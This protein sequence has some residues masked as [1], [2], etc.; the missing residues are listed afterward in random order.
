MNGGLPP[1]SYLWSNG[2]TNSSISNVCA[3]NYSCTVTDLVGCTIS[4]NFIITEPPVLAIQTTSVNSNCGLPDGTASVTNIT[5][6]TPGYTY[7]WSNGQT[8]Q[9]ATNLGPGNHTVTVT[10]ANNCAVSVTLVVGSNPGVTASVQSFANATC[11][12][13]CDGQ[14]TITTVGGTAPFTYTWTPNVG[15]AATLTNLCAGNY[16]VLVTDII[17]CT[18]TT[19]LS[20]SEPSL[21]TVTPQAGTTICVGQSVTLTANGA[22]GT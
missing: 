16:S 20:I 14:A 8:T 6:G 3:G 19:T 13:N 15:N 9:T 10:D 1:Y 11:F 17:G 4:S 22:G 2:S 5:G 12:S 18:S 7:L 21:L